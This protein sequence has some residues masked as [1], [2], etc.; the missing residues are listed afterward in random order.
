[1]SS[2]LTDDQKKSIISKGVF[3]DRGGKYMIINH[4]KALNLK[5]LIKKTHGGVEINLDDEEFTPAIINNL[6]SLVC[7]YFEKMNG[8]NKKP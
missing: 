4:L 3:L 1:M 6:H 8:L 7:S 5:N 2:Q